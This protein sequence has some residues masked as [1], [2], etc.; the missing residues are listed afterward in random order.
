M[1][2]GPCVGSVSM[3]TR[4]RAEGRSR[5]VPSIWRRICR[6]ESGSREASAALDLCWLMQ[7]WKTTEHRS[8]ASY[9][10][11]A[12]DSR[13]LAFCT[14]LHLG[15]M[16]GRAEPSLGQASLDQGEVRHSNYILTNPVKSV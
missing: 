4:T 16:R 1:G 8:M 10:R 3:A 7:T 14:M 13:A 9:E 5:P 2:A 11:I 12:Q 15:S 6:R